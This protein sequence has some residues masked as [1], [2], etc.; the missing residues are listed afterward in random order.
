[1]E[2]L[3]LTLDRQ[4]LGVLYIG[5]R[6]RKPFSDDDAALLQ[7]VGDR[8]ALAVDR[9]RLFEQEMVGTELLERMGQE[10]YGDRDVAVPLR[11]GEDAAEG[12]EVRFAGTAGSSTARA[13]PSPGS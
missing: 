1:V 10:V 13:T 4:L 3:A 5:T 12:D 8:V 6:D 7:L 9:A 11:T 2:R